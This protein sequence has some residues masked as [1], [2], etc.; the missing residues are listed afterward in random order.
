MNFAAPRETETC[1][2]D[3]RN[4]CQD[5]TNLQRRRPALDGGNGQDG[6]HL[7]HPI[8]LQGVIGFIG[9]PR[10]SSGANARP[11]R[12]ITLLDLQEAYNPDHLTGV[13][14]TVH[15]YCDSPALCMGRSSILHTCSHWR[16]CPITLNKGFTWYGEQRQ[17]ATNWRS[18]TVM[19][20]HPHDID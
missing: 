3:I 4:R 16:S 11:V 7:D 19:G 6:K 8:T 20:N 14:N 1:K 9:D 13:L 18:L 5:D 10:T 17:A 15:Q 12:T 2:G